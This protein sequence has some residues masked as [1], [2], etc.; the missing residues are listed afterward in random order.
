[1][2][3]GR[4]L[5]LESDG[6]LCTA[7]YT[8]TILTM[9]K[10]FSLRPLPR[11]LCGAGVQCPHITLYTTQRVLVWQLICVPMFPVTGPAAADSLHTELVTTVTRQP[12][13]V[14]FE[15]SPSCN[16]NLTTTA[17]VVSQVAT[18]ITAAAREILISQAT[19]HIKQPQH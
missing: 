12:V 15:N 10:N 11:V 2:A 6:Q 18:T 5:E 19:N 14:S 3:G 8:Y 1:M 16:I 17:A 9:T 4:V 7:Q 13:G